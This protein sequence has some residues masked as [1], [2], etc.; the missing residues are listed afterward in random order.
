[1]VIDMIMFTVI[2][3]GTGKIKMYYKI[4]YYKNIS[5][6]KSLSQF[7]LNVTESGEPLY[8]G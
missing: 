2:N 8:Y 6:M 4:L 5:Y 7:N 3:G 1:M